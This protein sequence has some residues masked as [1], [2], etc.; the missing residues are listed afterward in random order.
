MARRLLVTASMDGR[1][2]RYAEALRQAAQE[3]GSEGRLAGVLGVETDQL[4]RWLD[5]QD[6][7]PLSAFLRALGVIADGPYAR[8]GRR[9][10]VAAIR[11]EAPPSRGCS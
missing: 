3:L 11:S 6:D 5:R 2:E 9:I 1:Q 8:G 4:H 10:R 7:V